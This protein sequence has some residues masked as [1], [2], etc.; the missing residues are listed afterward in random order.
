MNGNGIVDPWDLRVSG[1]GYN[2][3]DYGFH[4][5]YP[6]YDNWYYGGGFNYWDY[7]FYHHNYLGHSLWGDD[8]WDNWGRWH[9]WDNNNEHRDGI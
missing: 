3:W 2:P 9:D 7:S 6:M 8:N 1:F 4:S 5:Y